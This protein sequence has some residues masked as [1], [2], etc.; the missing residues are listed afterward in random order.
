MRTEPLSGAAIDFNSVRR[1]LRDVPNLRRVLS[2]PP[3]CEQELI[4]REA[5]SRTVADLAIVLDDAA[6][7]EAVP[8]RA[9][10]LRGTSLVALAL[11]ENSVPL[12]T[13]DH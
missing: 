13:A 10:V 6:R 12:S 5:I 7:V 9:A 8:V 3:S 1:F 4:L 11:A 2:E